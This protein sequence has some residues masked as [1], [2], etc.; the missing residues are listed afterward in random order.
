MASGFDPM[1]TVPTLDRLLK[2]V[3]VFVPEASMTAF[4]SVIVTE[5]ELEMLPLF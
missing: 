4:G 5:V 3:P 1:F 2:D